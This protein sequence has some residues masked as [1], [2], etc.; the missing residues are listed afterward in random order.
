MAVDLGEGREG[1][2]R[3]TVMQWAQFEELFRQ[4]HKQGEHVSV[5]GPTGSGKSYAALQ[6]CRIVGERKQRNGRPSSVTILGIKYRDDT[7]TRFIKE[8]DYKV[9]K[10]WPPAYGEEHNVVWPKVKV[11]SQR[12]Y[13][14]RIKFVPLL[15]EMYQEGGQTVEISEAAYF[16]R[17]QPKGLG[18]SSQLEQFWSEARSG[19]ITVVAETQRP[20][21]V[22]LLMW[23]EPSWLII[24]LPDDIADLKRVA[25]ASGFKNQV[26]IAASR[27]GTHEFLCVAR[28][29]GQGGL[30]GL[31]VSRVDL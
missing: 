8:N 28:Q 2:G 18:M 24:F 17:P 29:R 9:I 26:M 6:L 14:H 27:L 12:P 19:K 10:K 15:D 22:T 20:R 13:Q 4:H 7:L 11:A 3:L 30:R 21:H 5:V 25:E 16:E 1:S 31:Y 23:T